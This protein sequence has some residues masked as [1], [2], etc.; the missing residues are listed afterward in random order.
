[1]YPLNKNLLDNGTIN[2]LLSHPTVVNIVTIGFKIIWLRACF[3]ED[4]GNSF[5]FIRIKLD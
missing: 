1:M 4:S 2:A 3:F 5:E